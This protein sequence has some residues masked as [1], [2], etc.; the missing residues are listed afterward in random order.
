MSLNF[1][2]NMTGKKVIP[3]NIR[4]TCEYC[5]RTIDTATDDH[6]PS[7]GAVYDKNVYL[8]Q[9]K[10]RQEDLRKMKL[11]RQKL[12]MEQQK[13]EVEQRRNAAKT[14]QSIREGISIFN[15][16]IDTLRRGCMIPVVIAILAVVVL[17]FAGIYNIFSD[18]DRIGN[19]GYETPPTQ[20][21]QPAIVE[22][23]TEAAFGEKAE[24][25]Q[26]S[27]V[28][29]KIEVYDYPYQAPQEGFYYAR[30]HLIVANKTAEKL[31]VPGEMVC[32]YEKEG[33]KLQAEENTISSSDLNTRIYYTVIHPDS[34]A[35]GWVY[36]EVPVGADLILKYDEYVTIHI[37]AEHCPAAEE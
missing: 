2:Y 12:E 14:H 32:Q 18:E 3:E 34:A 22:T 37:P 25:L 24:M 13:A 30:L 29:D 26:Y 9:H 7:C 35:E 27:V 28:C 23:P 21:T 6:C 33:Y 5:G 4:I 19:T 15:R 11:E 36:F 8:Q 17:L 1:K 10:Q 31:Q 16:V 20:T